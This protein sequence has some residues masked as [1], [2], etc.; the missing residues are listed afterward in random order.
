MKQLLVSMFVM[1]VTIL[2][3]ACSDNSVANKKTF[4]VG[5]DSSFRPYGY[6]ENGEIKGFDIDLA[7]EVAKRNQWKLELIPIEWNMKEQKIN[8]GEIDCIWNGFTINGREDDFTWSEPY[9]DNSQIIMVNRDSDIKADTDLTGRIIAVQYGTQIQKALQLGGSLEKLG[10]SLKA[11]RLFQNYDQAV[12]NLVAG[13]VDAIVLDIVVAKE[14]IAL[15]K[16]FRILDKE[17]LSEKYGIGFKKGNTA[18]RDRVQTTLKAMIADGTAAKISA[19]Y[20]NG[21]VIVM[22]PE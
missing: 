3:L 13:S 17:L 15:G 19:R 2:F 14:Q 7:R 4:S 12:D 11:L 22:K 20:F 6:I 10:A 9:V 1:G 16:N 18:L 5:F 21:N 8:R